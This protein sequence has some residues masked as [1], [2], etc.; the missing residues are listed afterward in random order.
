MRG[1]LSLLSLSAVSAMLF[2]CGGDI[3]YTCSCTAEVGEDYDVT[4]T[5]LGYCGVDNEEGPYLAQTWAH[6]ACMTKVSDARA[7]S[8]V[9]TPLETACSQPT[10]P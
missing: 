1:L 5:T 2:G 7:C 4:A 6:G 8:C 9:C 10:E 3:N